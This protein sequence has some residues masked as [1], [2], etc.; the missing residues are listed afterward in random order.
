DGFK[1][2]EFKGYGPRDSKHHYQK[3]NESKENSNDS[4]V[5]EQVSKDTSSFVESPLNVDKETA[6]SVDKKTEFVKPK[7]YDKP[8]RKS[9]RYAKIYRLQSPRGN[10]RN[11]NGQKSNQLGSDFVMYNKACFICGSF[12]HLQINCTH[13]QRKR[14]VSGNNYNMVDYN[15]YAKT[16]HPNAQRNMTPRA[17]LMKISLRPF[18][19][20]RPFYTAH[21]KPT[22]Y[23]ARPMT[24]FSKQAQSTVHG[25]FYKQTTLTNRYFHQKANTARPRVVNTARPYIAPGKPQKDDKGFI[26]SGCSRHM[27]GNIDYLLDFKK[28]DRGYVTFRGGAHGGRISGKEIENLVDKKVEIIRCDNGTKFKNKVMDD[29]CKEKGIKREYSVARTPRQNG[30]AERRNRTPISKDNRSN[31]PK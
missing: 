12:G 7:N 27:T 25:P 6:F 11:W 13:H 19:N 1:E 23:S 14:R 17:V 21:P 22:V 30:V 3:S 10:Q 5:K 8:V 29:F 16:T 18:N 31:P 9:V 26:N 4:F 28:F 24:H 20:V 2:P 15:Y